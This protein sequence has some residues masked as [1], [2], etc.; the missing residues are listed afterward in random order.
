M[1]SDEYESATGVISDHLSLITVTCC[2]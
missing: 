1:Y 2:L